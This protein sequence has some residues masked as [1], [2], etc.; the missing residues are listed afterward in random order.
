MLPNEYFSRLPEEVL[1]DWL[2]Q[3]VR[4][5]G[6]PPGL[7]R[8][9]WLPVLGDSPE[10]WKNLVWAQVGLNIDGLRWRDDCEE[11]LRD[12]TDACFGSVNNRFAS[13]VPHGLGKM[14]RIQSYAMEK[15]KLPGRLLIMQDKR[16]LFLVDGYHRLSWYHHHRETVGDACTVSAVAACFLGKAAL[17]VKVGS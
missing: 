2:P 14:R 13:H 10:R 15:R 9:K 7:C 5:L 3:R 16:G 4:N 1:R 17:T 8:E 12:L 6:W 11:T